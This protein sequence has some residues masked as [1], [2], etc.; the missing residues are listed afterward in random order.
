M[1]D[2]SIRKGAM[3]KEKKITEAAM[4]IGYAIGILEGLN[5]TCEFNKRIK[6]CIDQAIL[7]LRHIALFEL[8]QEESNP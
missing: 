2:V 3:K 7:G 6:D 8:S 4:E 5:D 1:G